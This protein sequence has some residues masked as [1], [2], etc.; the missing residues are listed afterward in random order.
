MVC[1][2]ALAVVTVAACGDDEDTNPT[3]TTS[4]T[5]GTG[6]NGGDGG[7]GGGGDGGGGKGG[8]DNEPDC[9]APVEVTEAIEEDTT[10]SADNCY[11]MKD[12]IFVEEGATLTIEPG[13][14]IMGDKESLATLVVKPGAKINAKGTA[15]KPIVFTSQSPKGERSAGDWGGVMLLGNAPI[16]VPGGKAEVEGIVGVEYGGDVEDDNSGVLEYVRIEFSGIL[17]SQDNEVNGL[18][19]AGVGS[20]TTVNHVMVHH[21][22]DDCF[23]FFGGT[24]NASHLICAQ[25]GDDGFDWDLGYVGKLQFLALQQ[26]PTVADETNGFE[27]DNDADGSE[28]APVSEPTIYNVTLCGKNKDVDKQQYGMLLRR[29]TKAHIF[30]TIVT[31]FEAGVDLRND[32][33]EVD[34]AS[35]IFFGNIK[36][37]IA[38]DETDANKSTESTLDDDDDGGADEVAWF[39]GEATNSAEDP[40]LA[41]C[42]AAK[43]DF[44]P[45]ATLTENAA[46]PP[47]DGFFDAE[48]AY[49]GAFK[50]DD[51]WATGAWVSFDAE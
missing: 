32:G 50:A 33:T 12:T 25:N 27:G 51:T 14:T 22:L 34:L 37:N 21:T 17:L 26:D 19:L 6:G 47:D 30:N 38:Y 13:T 15:D 7:G 10:W 29:G 16:N 42:F 48:A 46:T 31:G 8:G 5:S 1:A 23:E 20:K 41:G 36:A 2:S 43:P 35:S 39:E 40:E 3:G 28:N 49:I 9:D 44:R 4:T 11:L 45:A 24:V 18:T